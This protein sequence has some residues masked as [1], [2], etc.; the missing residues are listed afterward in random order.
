M[1]RKEKVTVK[2]CVGTACFVQGGADLL[3]YNEFLDPV[4]LATCELEGVS[5]LG[6]CKMAESNERPPF[7]E[8]NGKLYG[9]MTQE[10]LCKLLSEAIHA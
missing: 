7:V 4:V 8:I 2:I 10:K 5:C 3:L 6:G 1:N 9:D